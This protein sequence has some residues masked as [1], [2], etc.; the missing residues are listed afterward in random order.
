MEKLLQKISIISIIILL[1]GV[2]KFNIYYSQFNINVNEYIDITEFTVLFIDDFLFLLLCFFTPL[3]FI[4]VSMSINYIIK[5][6]QFEFF[7]TKVGLIFIILNSLH[8]IYKLSDDYINELLIIKVN[9]LIIIF[10]FLII[11]IDFDI[12]KIKKVF[13]IVPVVFFFLSSIIDPIIEAV[14][15]KKGIGTKKVEFMINGN[16]KIETNKRLIYLGR[17]KS[18]IFLYDKSNNLSFVYK[19][20]ELF[21]FKLLN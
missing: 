14:A 11:Y 17:T 10:S 4:L 1:C 21:S 3:I 5:K 2:L 13:I 15:L 20:D 6:F 8:E 16:N 9:V 18:F 7:Y 12:K 19:N